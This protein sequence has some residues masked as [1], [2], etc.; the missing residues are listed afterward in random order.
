MGWLQRL[1]EPHEHIQ[2]D[3]AKTPESTGSSGQYVTAGKMSPGLN[4]EYDRQLREKAG[5][6]Q[7]PPPPEFMGLEGEYDTN[8]L[9]K[10][11]AQAFDSDPEIEDLHTL[12][13][14]QSGSTVVLEGS[15]PN[16]DTLER[17]T[18]VAAKVD[19]SKS[20]DTT[21]VKVQ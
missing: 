15:V 10:R 11:V 17:F 19:G 8:G 3:E 1:L 13:V 12:Y 20:I 7:P 5:A 14:S 9:A 16:Q 21:R 6:H 18:A 4:G 2:A